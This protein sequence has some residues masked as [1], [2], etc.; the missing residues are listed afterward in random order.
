LHCKRRSSDSDAAPSGKP[1]RFPLLP[2]GTALA[3][4]LVLGLWLGGLGGISSFVDENVSATAMLTSGAD[5]A[6]DGLD[7]LFTADNQT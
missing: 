4:S 6:P 7:D 1:R 5:F 3:A 2:L